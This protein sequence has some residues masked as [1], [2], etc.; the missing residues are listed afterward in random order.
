MV[1]VTL[2]TGDGGEWNHAVKIA[3]WC[4]CNSVPLVISIKIL[5][6]ILSQ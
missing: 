5:V 4:F 6:W 3:Q 1:G 2:P